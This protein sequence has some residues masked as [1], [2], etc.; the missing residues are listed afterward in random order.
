MASTEAP[1]PPAIPSPIKEAF[2]QIH[3]EAPPQPPLPQDFALL[4]SAERTRFRL[5][6]SVVEA[7][8]TQ[9]ETKASHAI[10]RAHLKH[11]KESPSDQSALIESAGMICM[12]AEKD[13]NWKVEL[14]GPR[15][16]Q[17]IA[18]LNKEM[19]SLTT[20]I[21]TMVQP[22][23]TKYLEGMKLATLGRALLDIKRDG[24]VK[25][26]CV[27]LGCLE[28]KLKTD[29]PNFTYYAHVAKFTSLRISIMRRDRRTRKLAH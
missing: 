8:E 7:M 15:R 17:V 3:D 6:S 29:G 24:T 18:A 9:D 5:H 28:N 2:G 10:S 22:D 23:D 26:R 11:A 14:A 1:T 19:L 4:S 16:E 13:M 25:V 20:T 27:K 12:L 21:L